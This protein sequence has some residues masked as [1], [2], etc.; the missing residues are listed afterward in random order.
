MCTSIVIFLI[1]ACSLPDR[2]LFQKGSGGLYE[3]GVSA[4]ELESEDTGPTVEDTASPDSGLFEDTGAD[5][6]AQGDTGADDTGIEDTG[7]EDTE[8]EDSGTD[9]GGAEE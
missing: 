6:T 8:A 7:A 1:G 2:S 5:D 3:G 9:S 4:S